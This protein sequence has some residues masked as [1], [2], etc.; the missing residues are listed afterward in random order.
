VRLYVAFDC[1]HCDNPVRQLVFVL[2]E[3]RGIPVVDAGVAANTRFDCDHCGTVNWTGD[4]EVYAES[5]TDL[6]DEE[7]QT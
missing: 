6:D 7:T 3:H 4:L 2:D 5:P 1:E